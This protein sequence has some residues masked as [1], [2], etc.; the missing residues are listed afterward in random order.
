[1]TLTLLPA[2]DRAATAW[3]NGGGVTRE[4]AA[5]GKSGDGG[6]L[7]DFLWRISLADVATDGPFSAFEGY[8]RVITLV[9][10][11][12][13]V[14]TIDGVEHRVDAPFEP[15]G[16]S[17]GSRTDCVLIGGP[18]VDFNVMTRSGAATAEVTILKLSAAQAQAPV[19]VA[20]DD[21]R[22]VAVAV[23]LDG[24]AEVRCGTMRAELGAF[25]AVMARAER[26]EITTAADRAVVALVLFEEG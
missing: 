10:G 23:L 22:S 19:H 12:G 14:L 8:D 26:L 5:V 6:P 25:D 16:F 21:A 17:G 3:K 9:R 15:L 18:I 24:R 4:V 1:M 11:A 2:A 20:L 7:G 13:M